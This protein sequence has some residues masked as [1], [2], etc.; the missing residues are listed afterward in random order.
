MNPTALQFDSQH[1]WHPYTSL[2]NPLPV[3]PVKEAKGVY[4][5]L[6]DGRALIDGMASWWCMIHGYQHPVM[7]QALKNQIDL[8]SHVMF[9][10]ITHQPAIDLAEKL[11]KMTPKQLNRVF[12]ADSG[13]VAVEVALKMAIQYWY[14][15]GYPEKKHFVTIRNGYHGDTFGAMSVCDP[16]TGMHSLYRGVLPEHY[17]AD[18]PICRF[19]EACCDEQIASLEQILKRH[20]HHIAAL[21]LE[22]V[23]QGAGGMWFYSADYLIKA[24]ELCQTYDVLVIFDEIATGFG[25]TGKLFAA[26]HADICPDIMCLGKALTGGYLT[27][28]A[29]VA[30]EKVGNT[31][32]QGKPGVFMHG[33]TFMGNPL[34]CAAANASIDLLLNSDWKNKVFNIE[35][36]LKKQLT[37]CAQLDIVQEVRVLGAIGVVELKKTVNMKNIQRL[38]VEAGIWL[39]PFGKLIYLMPPYI[40][41]DDQL[42]QL[43][44]TIY[45]ILKNH[46][47]E[48]TVE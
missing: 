45:S 27:M 36:K 11:V 23:V 44:G 33:P 25:R 15:A 16:I 31:I 24:V 5:Y 8:M 39:R 37:Q 43:A 21:I 6:E 20:H 32:S 1:I 38:F 10:G 12:F 35:K 47:N 2:K 48:V 29:V 22:P 18:K 40:I 41:T 28:S 17:F 34:S 26:E 9:G 42:Q 46:P 3:Y 19:G 30:T 13:S 7:N 14:T 4:L